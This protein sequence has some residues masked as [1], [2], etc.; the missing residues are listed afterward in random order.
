MQFSFQFFFYF[1]L[2]KGK[3]ARYQQL[4]EYCDH[5]S[6]L[7]GDL[8]QCDP[9]QNL[10]CTGFLEPDPTYPVSISATSKF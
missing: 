5:I 9:T 1:D 4:G 2:F 7:N 6:E 8:C 3:C 10:V